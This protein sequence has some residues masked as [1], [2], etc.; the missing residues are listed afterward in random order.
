MPTLLRSS[1]L[2][3]AVS[4]LLAAGPVQAQDGS[5][6][7]VADWIELTGAG[8]SDWL[9]RTPQTAR[10]EATVALA[11]F[12]AA[13]AIEGAYAP[14]G[15][16]LSAPSG[17]S[18]RAAAAS[19]AHGVLVA[20]YPER[21]EE[22]DRALAE[23]LE[24]VPDGTGEQS[25]VVLGERAARAALA[26]LTLDPAVPVEPFR[27]L[28]EPGVYV[29]TETPNVIR[30]FDLALRPWVLASPS[31]FRPPPPPALT[32]E[33]YA[34]DLDEVRRVGAATGVQRSAEQTVSASFWFFIPMNPTLRRMTSGGDRTLADN[35]RLYAMFYMATDDA[36]SASADAKA[37]YLFWRPTTALRNA[38]RDG[39]DA[40]MRVP[41]WTP[42]LP[43]PMLPE[44]PCAHCVQAA[45]H[46]VVLDAEGVDAPAEG[47][48]IESPGTP[49]ETR[50]IESFAD[51]SRETLLS[52]IYAGAH[53][54]FS[55]EAGEAM[56]RAIGER[57]LASF[58]RVDESKR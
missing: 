9:E 21:A 23:D 8:Y 22:L 10:P 31:E 4:C 35:A 36:W 40:T 48:L 17:V 33:R 39:A 52:R 6:N 26:R 45:A 34:R 30:D 19:A 57:L 5:D 27:A 42:L 38:D 16:P 58:A 49:G 24:G 55:N 11:M 37:H 14:F 28:A 56:G 53:Y 25:G 13:N 3:I 46:A 15:E 2:A 51:Y 50:R 41:D 7:L 32:S 43:S 54:R 44:Y 29:P 20:L 47:W 12:E 18:Q 1:V